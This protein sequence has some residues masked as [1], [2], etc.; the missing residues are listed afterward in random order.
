[1]NM[2]LRALS[3]LKATEAIEGHHNNDENLRRKL[4]IS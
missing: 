4:K 3:G 2:W 1:M